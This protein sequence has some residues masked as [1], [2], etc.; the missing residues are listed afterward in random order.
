ML[1]YYIRHGDPTY[2]PDALTPLGRRQAE[3]V[4]K[5]LSVLGVDRI[6]SSTSTRAFQT[7]QPTAEMLKKEVT[8]MDF[9]HENHAWNQL[10]LINEQGNR[11]W[12]FC[13]PPTKRLFASEEIRAL[14]DR[15]YT[16]PQI[17]EHHFEQGIER[18]RTHADAWLASLGYEHD[19]SAH[20]YKA[21]KPN[22][23]RIALFAHEGF[24]LAFLSCVLDVP[25]PLMSL[26]F[27]MGH[28]GMTVID[29]E[30]VGEGYALARALMVAN[31]SHLYHEGLHTSYQNRIRI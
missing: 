28:T 26:H 9:C 5:R 7:A 20:L 23:E 21:V 18:I 6:F 13:H 24:G 31:D 11:T 19:H 2:D 25:Y 27:G 30:D 10:S 12:A 16:H 4:G 17:A 29:F 8:Q 14:G 3:A 1:L 22:N 15:W